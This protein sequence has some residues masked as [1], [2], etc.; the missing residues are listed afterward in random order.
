M[1]LRFDNAA[2]YLERTTGA[3]SRTAFT[4]MGWFKIVVD[5]NAVATFLRFKASGSA[6]N[7]VVS[8]DA[9]GVTLMVF[10]NSV[11]DTGTALNVGDWNHIAMVGDDTNV[12]IFLNGI[13]DCQVAQ[14]TLTLA[15]IQVGN[16]PEFSEFLNGLAAAVKIY[17][18]V[19]TAAEILQESL[20]YAPVRFADLNAWYPMIDHATADAAKD[21]STFK[22]DFTVN[23]TLAI[24]NG[25]PI[26]WIVE[27]E[28]WVPAITLPQ[29]GF[30]LREDG[31]SRYLREDGSSF[32]LREGGAEDGAL[33]INPAG[34]ASAEIF[35]SHTVSPGAVTITP[36]GIA[37]A[38]AFG[39]AS[40]NH[41]IA[42]TGIASA[43]AFGTAA[44]NL[45]IAATGIASAEAFGSHT[46]AATFT[47]TANGIASA[48]A[49]GSHA[50]TVAALTVS[51][52]GIDSAEAF[53]SHTLTTGNVNILPGAIASAEAFG[54]HT[55]EV[56]ALSVSPNGIASA[57]AFGS[58]TVTPG[59][60]TITPSGI[61]S[62]EV[63][64]SQVVTA[65]Y[66][67]TSTGIGSA[68]AFGQ[69]TI[70]LL[71]AILSPL[72][73]ASLEVFGAVVV[74]GGGIPKALAIDNRTF[75]VALNDERS[76]ATS[77]TDSRSIQVSWT[78]DQTIDLG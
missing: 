10:N 72:G 43:E 76:I 46:L 34:I 75:A 63:F 45:N 3:P 68:E 49:F 44:L 2:D 40:V 23:G 60:V 1:S 11:T 56:G 42:P 54:S 50:I 59:A 22:R 62:A 61:A 25:P 37:S 78:D 71:L 57:E 67:I 66:T 18:V 33:T 16:A 20:Q 69:P 31:T 65:T 55:V 29:T 53:G 24:E 17:D 15:H 41:V 21:Y 64:G 39:T 70:N 28:L 32:Y 51:P 26:P 47:I 73:I 36:S 77:L 9:D 12:T 14:A 4:M 35:G 58:H 5:T 30:Y 19:L 8:T 48:E 52:A 7:F 13:Q 6:D 38:E 27:D 74:T